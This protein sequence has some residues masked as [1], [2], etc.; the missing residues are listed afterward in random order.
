MKD[1]VNETPEIL[2]KYKD[3]IEKLAEAKSRDV[4]QNNDAKHAAIVI[5]TMFKNANSV[6]RIFSKNLSGDISVNN[7]F[8]NDLTMLLMGVDRDNQEIS[9]LYDERNQA[10]L[11]AIERVI[12]AAKKHGIT[13][14]VCGQAPSDYPEFAE[15][16]VD[17]GVTSISLT[18]DVI[19]RTRELVYTIEKKLWQKSKK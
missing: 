6:I 2:K 17:W 14:S 18:P 7:D 15:K 19:D 3:A 5:S 10:V 4:I 13:V 12:K 11:W 8:L 1:I 16:L 9:Y